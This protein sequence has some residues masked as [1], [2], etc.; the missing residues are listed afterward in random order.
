MTFTPWRASCKPIFKEL[1][2]MTVPNLTIFK[3]LL[4]VQEN[5]E[6]FCSQ[7]FEHT[8]NTRF[9]NNFQYP[10]HRLTLV[11]K[12]PTYMGKKLFN[13]L[14][15]EYKNQIQSKSFKSSLTEFLLSNTYYSINEFLTD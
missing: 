2:I 10:R 9:K 5:F 11:E 3:T 14:P 15:A 7:N 4:M 13:K 1:K 6:K 8:Y 12:T